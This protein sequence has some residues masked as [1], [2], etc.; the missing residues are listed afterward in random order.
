VRVFGNPLRIVGVLFLLVAWEVIAWAGVIPSRYFPPLSEL[1]PALLGLIQ[2]GELKTA[3][4]LTITRIFG[5]LTIACLAAFVLAI[6]TTSCEIINDMLTPLIEVLRPLPP[7]ALIPV[8][9][10]FLGIGR[11]LFL[12]IIAFAAVWPIYIS[13]AN[14]LR[15]V[16]GALIETGASLG[17][18][19][20]TTL[21]QI[22]FP[23][24][25]PEIFTG[26]RV[27]AGVALIA[28][29][30]IEM[31]AGR[32][33]IGNLLFDTTFS[34]RTPETYGVI[35]VAG[36]NGLLINAMFVGLR[37][38]CIGWHISRSSQL[39]TDAMG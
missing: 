17:C 23:A 16:D 2:S 33:G 5:G 30:V 25:M 24:A 36:A 3:E 34:N 35:V 9:I 26:L 19:P 11:E 28:T 32:G 4:V 27:G 14:A 38:L 7:A 31:L 21:L 10:F 18:G 1:P 22:R 8:M 15:S 6:A 12:F 37:R 20:I 13:T 29:V 39:T